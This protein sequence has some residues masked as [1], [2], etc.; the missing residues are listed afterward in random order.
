MRREKCRVLVI[1]GGL[2]GL[3]AAEVATQ[4]VDEVV[5]VDKRGSGSAP[6]SVRDASIVAAYLAGEAGGL[7]TPYFNRVRAA[8]QPAV[9]AEKMGAVSRAYADY[10]RE[11]IDTGGG[12]SDPT[13]VELTVDGIYN[14][15]GW[16]E[17]YGLHWQRTEDK[18][19]A[20]FSA[21]GQGAARLAVLQEGPAAVMRVLEQGARHLD[22]RFLQRIWITR[23][24]TC[25]GR[26]Q[27]A[28]GIDLES[29]DPVVFE[30]CSVILACGGSE[31]LYAEA[32]GGS[33]G[34]GL[35]LALDAGARLANMEFVRFLP[36]PV[37]ARAEDPKELGLLLLGLGLTLQNAQGE[38]FWSGGGSPAHLAQGLHREL[39]RGP[40]TSRFP[41]QAR[42]RASK[43][44][45]IQ[46]FAARAG[47][48]IRWRIACGGLLGGI[49]HRLFETGV[50]GLFVAGET[51]TGMH[52]ADALAGVTTSYNFC[53]GEEAGI[54]AA[55]QSLKVE[56]RP[57]E[58]S[59]VQA[60][61]RRLSS[62]IAS[63]A[64]D[65]ALGEK[66]EARIRQAMWAGAGPAR[67]AAGL[68]AAL[69]ELRA[70][71]D[72]VS[73]SKAGSFQELRGV[74]AA[75]HLARVGTLVC[76][77]ALERNESCGQHSRRDRP[78]RKVSA[79]GSK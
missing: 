72:Q 63:G 59:Q 77:A 3:Q 48:E 41:A 2:A 11:I 7:T 70:I 50:A 1:G 10:A 27:G 4:F 25:D 46:P 57:L 5:L 9:P 32:R 8:L 6:G 30:A 16:M 64:G 20:A 28:Y 21:P 13:L 79:G 26:A 29:G 23:L 24:L 34:D 74:L 33:S 12:L 61:A 62:L 42:E 68:A 39:A 19:F 18:A 60:E 58:E 40:V 71:S 38:T 65:P 35:Q 67:D 51:S 49:A 66:V 36:E 76:Q 78:E 37:D 31:R 17:A 56:A 44:A 43:I 14:R 73:R 52:G 45:A 55:K 69:K 53:S 47:E 15:I 54:R 22:G 75:S